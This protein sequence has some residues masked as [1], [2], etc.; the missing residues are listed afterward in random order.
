MS[1]CVD[2][3][4]DRGVG[5][6][7]YCPHESVLP[8]RAQSIT[9]VVVHQA[10]DGTY[11]L[12]GAAEAAV[13]DGFKKVELRTI[14]EIQRFEREM[15][16]QLRVEAE[17]VQGRRYGITE[18]ERRARHAAL[19]AHRK[20]MSTLGREFARSAIEHANRGRR[21]NTDPGFHVEALHYDQSNREPQR[22]ERTDW[23]PRRV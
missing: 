8:S 20:G 19:R 16:L 17:Q 23:R 15:N 13:P 7:P 22:D 12:P 3:G 4:K 6:W 9:P 18:P 5:D 10:A 2:C 14:P 11:R 21:Q 1:I